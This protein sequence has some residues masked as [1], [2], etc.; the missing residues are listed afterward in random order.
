MDPL[1]RC[2][3]DYFESRYLNLIYDGFSKLK[4]RKVID[5]IVKR[6]TENKDP[7]HP[8]LSAII[9]NKKVIYDLQDGLN[10]IPGNLE[11][12]LKF[13]Q[14]K[15]EVDFYFKRSFNH[16]LLQYAPKGCRVL[17]LGLNFFIKYD[18]SLYYANIK[19]KITDAIKEN[20]F[21]AK[22]LKINN[23]SFAIED[24]EYYPLVTPKPKILFLTRL[25]NPDE[26]SLPHLKEEREIIN[27][28]RVECIEACR[29]EFGAIFTGGL[30][31]DEFSLKY[32]P[33]LVV[34]S[35]LTNKSNFLQATKEH[36]ICISTA[37]LLNSIGWKFGEY[38]TASRAIVSEPLAYDLPGDFL[39]GKNF[40]PFSNTTQLLEHIRYL[41]TNRDALL[42]MMKANFHYY[43]N[44]VKPENQ[45]LNTL[46]HIVEDPIS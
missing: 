18:R 33:S 6:S 12:N 44:Y 22:P 40:L 27:R 32:A 20:K 17:P 11:E 1:I 30:Q 46:L 26:V 24:Y 2:E 14:Q 10:W 7:F 41:L 8:V 29:K 5:L 23:H 3:L 45:M 9:N 37:G 4:E 31:R 35:S 16:Q 15:Y 28:T 34:P 39:E 36:A 43:N 19:T 13:F 38:V 21:L 42:Q 25:W